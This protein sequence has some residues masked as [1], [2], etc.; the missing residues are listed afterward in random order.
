MEGCSVDGVPSNELARPLVDTDAIL[1]NIANEILAVKQQM[2][3]I[4]AAKDRKGVDE[5]M[6]ADLEKIIGRM[7]LRIAQL[8]RD[9]DAASAT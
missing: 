7:S 1:S 6:R 5:A 2:Q 9:A 3:S 4:Q 8:E